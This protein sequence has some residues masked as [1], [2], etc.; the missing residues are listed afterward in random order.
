MAMMPAFQWGQGGQALTPEQAKR[1]RAVAEA[2]MGVQTDPQ[3]MWEGIQSAVGQIGGALQNTRLDA[4]EGE[5]RAQVAQALA[6]A[7]ASGDPNALLGVI[8]NDWASDAERQIASLLYEQNQPKDPLEVGG[9]LVDPE[10]YQPLFD[11]RTS[12]AQ[13]PIE[14]NGQLVDPNTFE[15]LGDFRNAPE[16][17]KPLAVNDQL[18]DPTTGEIIG[19]FRDPAPVSPRPMTPEE[20]AMWGIPETDTTPYFLDDKGQPKAIG[21]GGQTINVGGNND[22]GTIPSGMMVTRD[23]AGNV[24]GMSPIPGGPADIDAAAA[25]NQ[26]GTQ[27]ETD[28]DKSATT[29]ATTSAVLDLLDNSDQPVTGTLSRPFALLSN[30]PAGRIRSYVTTLQSGVALS[31]M[32]RLKEASSTGAT[33]FGQMN[34]KE[35]GLLINDIGAL[36][37]DTTEP[38]IFRATVK[39]IEDR[40]KRVVEDIKRNVSPERIAELGLQDLLASFSE[41]GSSG[42]GNIDYNAPEPP[43]EWAGDPT[44]WQFMSPEDR[45]LW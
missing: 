20:R 19:D 3:N 24:T 44:L 1:Q 26:A 35:L 41:G 36:D 10:T 12:E 39:R 22:I 15:V 34:Q 29:L 17:P 30:T 27:I 2:L 16:A 11:S 5:A 7:Q 45:A 38:D 14:V 13:K 4:Q 43:P 37:P 40:A 23:A 6:E 21:G 32:M 8:G 42:A 9:V 31:T 33:G 18:V 28:L 25:A